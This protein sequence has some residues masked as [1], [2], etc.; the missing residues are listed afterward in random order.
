MYPSTRQAS[1]VSRP[2]KSRPCLS[3]HQQAPKRN[4]SVNTVSISSFHLHL[5]IPIDSQIN[6][7]GRPKSRHEARIMMTEII[8]FHQE[9]VPADGLAHIR[10]DLMDLGPGMHAMTVIV[11]LV[12]VELQLPAPVAPRLDAQFFLRVAKPFRHG[13]VSAVIVIAAGHCPAVF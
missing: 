4:L 1:L 2:T 5:L 12:L 3:K 9:L 11:P 10:H 8:V 7:L 13:L 6:R